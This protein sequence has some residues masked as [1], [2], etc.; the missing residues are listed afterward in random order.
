[1]ITINIDNFDYSEPWALSFDERLGMLLSGSLKIA[2]FYE[3]PN[4]ST[5]RYRAHNMSEAL[6]FLSDRS[7][8]ASYFFLSDLPNV[9]S[10][11]DA[12]DLLVICRSRYSLQLNCLIQRFRCQRKK[13]LFDIDDLVFDVDYAHLLI[14]SLAN[15]GASSLVMDQWFAYISRMGAALKMCDGAIT[16]N[17]FLASR[18]TE[19]SGLSAA[20]V[21]NFLNSA[22]QL[23]SDTI[24]S[25]KTNGEFSTNGKRTLGYFSGSPSHKLDFA[26]VV[27][28]LAQLLED[29]ES[30]ELVVAGYIELE[31][32]LSK[33]GNRIRYYPFQDYVNLQKLIASVDLN[34]VPLQDN[35]FTNC[36][37]ELKYFEAGVVGV[38]SVASPVFTY[39]GSIS[40]G[41]NGYLARSYQWTETIARALDDISSSKRIANCARSH[42]QSNYSW[43]SQFDTILN[44][45][46]PFVNL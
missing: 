22:Q 41:E 40:H 45:L 9:R 15:N 8:S 11:V 12:A 13:V 31:H 7:V 16:T 39:R 24:Y 25:A 21:P 26:L 30:I 35:I 4:N 28:S 32:S 27:P 37:S 46:T 1:M 17:N 36:K 33:F 19:F 6:N 43:D 38:P 29:D 42:S 5:F 2:Y 10:I 14:N 23:Y 3:E 18:V 44:A 34:L 20:V